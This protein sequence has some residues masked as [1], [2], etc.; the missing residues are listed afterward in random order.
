MFQGRA[1]RVKKLKER[2]LRPR[3]DQPM[4]TTAT[5]AAQQLPMPFWQWIIARRLRTSLAHDV[6]A[7]A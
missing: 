3:L 7:P 1:A 6:A 4:A 2:T 5:R